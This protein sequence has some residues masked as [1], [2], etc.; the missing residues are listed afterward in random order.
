MSGWYELRATSLIALICICV[1]TCC[2]SLYCAAVIFPQYHVLYDRNALLWAALVVLSF[3][4]ISLLFAFANFSF[5]YF[6]GFYVYIMVAGYLWLNVFSPLSY[7]HAL[8]G[9]SAAAS[10]V[11]F[12][13][14]AL[15]IC[16][17]IKQTYVLSIG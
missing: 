3:A 14:P 8:A 15:L 12:L 2:L 13:L 4:T 1:A 16:S 5:G 9:A 6:V 11:S 17:P 10:A 7:N